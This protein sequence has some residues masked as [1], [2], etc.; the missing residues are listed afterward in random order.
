MRS[1]RRKLTR[2][3]GSHRVFDV[4]EHEMIDADGAPL[5]TAYTFRCPDW[6]SIVP[7]TEGGEIVLV[8]QY[9][10]GIDDFT[11]EVP[12]GVVDAG[13][14][15]DSGALRELREE[16]GYEAGE[17]ASLGVVHPNPPLQDNRYHMYLAKGARRVGEPSFDVGEFCEVVLAPWREVEA[18]TRSGTIT[19]ALVLL[20]LSRAFERLR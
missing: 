19:H 2:T 13:E 6:A 12:G 10:H 15:A 7:V 11:L 16:T 3:V 4:L 8:R 1:P 14:D 5:R 20:A 17:L 18:M 9:R